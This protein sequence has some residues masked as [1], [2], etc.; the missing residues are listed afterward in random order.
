MIPIKKQKQLRNLTEHLN[1]SS[2]LNM[3]CRLHKSPSPTCS[4]AGKHEDP[5]PNPSEWEIDYGSEHASQRFRSEVFKMNELDFAL[6]SAYL[7][8][9]RFAKQLKTLQDVK[10]GMDKVRRTRP[11]VK[12]DLPDCLKG[13]EWLMQLTQYRMTHYKLMANFWESISKSDFARARI[14]VKCICANADRVDEAASEL[15]SMGAINEG[16]YKEIIEDIGDDYMTYDMMC[17]E[18]R[19]DVRLL[20]FREHILTMSPDK[21]RLEGFICEVE[22]HRD[23]NAFSPFVGDGNGNIEINLDI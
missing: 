10:G 5:Q 7:M 19:N 18:E 8:E 1:E 14:V 11:N 15:V 21:D 22:G 4:I 20:R 16:K 12:F 13:E 9:K 17:K 23:S 6:A 3:V 2:T